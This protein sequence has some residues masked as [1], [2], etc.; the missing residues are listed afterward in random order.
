MN[1]SLELLSYLFLTLSGWMAR[2]AYHEKPSVILGGTPGVTQLK[3][4]FMWKI[5]RQYRNFFNESKIDRIRH[6]IQK[7]GS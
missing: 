6:S 7:T 3:I 5:N 1:N 2:T 4:Y